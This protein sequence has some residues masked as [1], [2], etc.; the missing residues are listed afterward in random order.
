MS[1][2]AALLVASAVVALLLGVLISLATFYV[3]RYGPAGDG[4]SFRGNGAITVYFAIPAVIAGGWTAIAAH[5]SGRQWL[6]L[7][8]GAG[9][10][11]L[12]LALFDAALL[13]LFGPDGDRF[14][15]P[16]VSVAVLLWMIAAPLFAAGPKAGRFQPVLGGLHRL[17]A[18][19]FLAGTLAGVVI[20]GVLLPAGS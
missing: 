9:L 12:T 15:T 8:V 20:G 14:W 3:A 6:L 18:G 13:P 5:Q 7:G 17:A 16:L 1:G 10:V 4:W 2:R 19:I 11:G